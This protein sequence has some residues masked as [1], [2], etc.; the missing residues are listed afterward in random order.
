MLKKKMKGLALEQ[1]GLKKTRG[2][3][4]RF[5]F[6]YGSYREWHGEWGWSL[7]SPVF[8]G[9]PSPL[10]E[11]LEI[12]VALQRSD[13][14]LPVVIFPRAP[15]TT[16]PTDITWF[17]EEFAGVGRGGGVNEYAKKNVCSL[18]EAV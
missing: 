15:K 2:S 16:N 8:L 3:E 4:T 10:R 11:T 17:T 18:S 9:P 6:C 7:L 5:T 13:W 14:L 1:T 12:R